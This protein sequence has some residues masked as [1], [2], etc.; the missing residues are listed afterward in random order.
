MDRKYHEPVL[1]EET[2]EALRIEKGGRYI[3]CTLGDGGH[4]LEILKR[5]GNVL[6]V[7]LEAGSLS[8]GNKR[9]EEAGFT[10]SFVGVKG[11][12]AN[13]DKIAKEN[14]FE[15]ANGILYDLGYSSTQLKDSELGLS[16]LGDQPLDMRADKELTVT[17]ADLVN[18]LPEKELESLFREYGEEKYAKR[19]AQAIVNARDLKKLTST[20]DLTDVIIDAAPP[21]YDNKR[22]HPAT[23]VFQSLRVAVNSELANLKLSLPRAARLLLP[24]GRMAVIAFHS[25]EDRVVKRFGSGVQPVRV[26][27]KKPIVPSKKE[28]QKNPRARSAR[29]RIFER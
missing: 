10:D 28:V 1:L 26:V 23:R 14:G 29:L 18:A 2:I 8:R 5:G 3:D 25:L 16:F 15:K 27:N 22:L 13:I 4:A 20:K 6:G 12:F 19:F 21:G 17:A 11:N 24:G 7:E 9:I